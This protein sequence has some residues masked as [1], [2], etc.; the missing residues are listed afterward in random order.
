MSDSW[1][2]HQICNCV[3]PL[4]YHTRAPTFR[5]HTFHCEKR[6]DM[7]WTADHFSYNVGNYW[8][9]DIFNVGKKIVACHLYQWS[10]SNLCYLFWGFPWLPENLFLARGIWKTIRLLVLQKQYLQDCIWI[11]KWHFLAYT[12]CCI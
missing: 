11:L 7:V 3:N 10:I 6:I 12:R 2:L 4:D 1:T 8:R 9:Q 5:Q